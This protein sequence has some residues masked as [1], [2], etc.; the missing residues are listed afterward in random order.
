MNDIP[1]PLMSEFLL[2]EF[3]LPKNITARD[4]SVGT[5]IP[6][7]EVRAMLADELDITPEISRKLAA[8]FGVSSS[9]FYDIQLDLKQRMGVGELAYA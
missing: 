3:M 4:L 7:W 6:L 5:G 1:L 2:D 8:Y 9:L